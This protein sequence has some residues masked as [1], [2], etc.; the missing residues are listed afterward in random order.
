[1]AEE[2]K[3]PRDISNEERDIRNYDCNAVKDSTAKVLFPPND[4]PQ[5]HENTPQRIRLLPGQAPVDPSTTQRWI[6]TFE[7][8]EET[9]ETQSKHYN[10]RYNN[11]NWHFDEDTNTFVQVVIDLTAE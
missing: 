8:N 6:N 5:Q 7:Y 10:A 11:D 3:S 1:M 4:P 9:E 2:I